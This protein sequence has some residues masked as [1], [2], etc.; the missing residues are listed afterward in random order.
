V[1]NQTIYGLAA[2]IWTTSL[3]TAHRVAREIRAGTVWVNAAGLYDPAVSFGGYKQSGFGR[4]L[5][6][7][8]MEA[9]TQVKSVWLNLVT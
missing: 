6:V 3:A 7:H 8:S 4:E 9:Y 5:G 1:A 2:A